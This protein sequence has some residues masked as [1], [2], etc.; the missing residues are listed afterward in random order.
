MTAFNVLIT[1]GL[2]ETGQAI[3]HSAAKV[4]DRAGISPEELLRVIKDYDALIVRSRTRVT[5][6]VIRA[7]ERLKVIGRA[8]VGVDN[9]DLEAARRNG[10]TV[11]NAPGSITMAAAELTFGLMLTLSREIP[12]ADAAMKQGEWPKKDLV[13]GNLTA[14]RLASSGWGVSVAR[15]ADAQSY[16]GWMLLPTIP[17]FRTK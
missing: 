7:A 10:V 1:D 8:G 16:L 4:D 2:N 5:E 3:L 13:G 14:R 12:R 15:W 6:D 17:C 11:I 9:I